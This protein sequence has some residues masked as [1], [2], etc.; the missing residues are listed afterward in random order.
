LCK[1][2]DNQPGLLTL[3]EELAGGT[4]T[5]NVG[6]VSRHNMENNAIHAKNPLDKGSN[7]GH[8]SNNLPQNIVMTIRHHI[9]VS[10]R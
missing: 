9:D 5:N 8:M 6:F 10:I 7:Y 1:Y 4:N 3:A 2:Y